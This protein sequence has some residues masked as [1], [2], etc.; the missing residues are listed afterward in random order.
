MHGSKRNTYVDIIKGLLISSVVITHVAGAMKAGEQLSCGPYPFVPYLCPFDMPLFMAISGY[1]FYFSCCKRSWQEIALNRFSMIFVPWVV[2]CWIVQLVW[3]GI[4]HHCSSLKWMPVGIWFP[5]SLL[6]CCALTV[7]LHCV[8][9]AKGWVGA[10]GVVFLSFFIGQDVYNIGYMF[11]FFFLGYLTARWSLLV[12][13]RWWHGVFSLIIFS[14]LWS[15]LGTPISE[16]WSIWKSHTYLFGP[17]GPQRHMELYL[18]RMGIGFFGCVS[19]AWIVS[20]LCRCCR[21]LPELSSSCMVIHR[22]LLALGEYSLAIYLIQ[23]VLVEAFLKKMMISFVCYMGYNPLLMHPTLFFYVILP[24]TTI[25][26]LLL[27]LGVH[28]ILSRKKT[29]ALIIFGK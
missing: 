1:F 28:R 19:F 20:L 9:G 11:P 8:F 17:F 2:W 26:F 5:G 29:L 22:F 24:G 16:N 13:F 7:L 6:G 12:R 3:L 18:Y 25:V 21:R 14:A 4:N 27:S 23:S 10:L 15:L